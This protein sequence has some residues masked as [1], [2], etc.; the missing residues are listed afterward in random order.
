MNLVLTRLT[1][2]G[3]ATIGTLA[4]PG[5]TVPLWTL[6]DLWKG[7]K[8]R[9]SC[10]PPAPRYPCKPHG[11][12]GEPVKFKKTYEVCKVPGR[13]AILFHAG[14][15]DIDTQG[16]ILVGLGVR[17]GKLINSTEAMIMLQQAI[18]KKDFDLQVIDRVS[19]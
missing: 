18:G 17:L 7:N 10:I 6:E 16:C 4:V 2:Q 14:N 15:T 1:V 13:S 8:P 19:L 12:N 5:L 9:E 3:N 11:W